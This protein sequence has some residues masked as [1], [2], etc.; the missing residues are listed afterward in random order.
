MWN[1]FME[2]WDIAGYW[3][4]VS[5][6]VEL[7]CKVYAYNVIECN[8]TSNWSEVLWFW[9]VQLMKIRYHD[10]SRSNVTCIIKMGTTSSV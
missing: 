7:V 2:Y 6:S 1:M 3:D 4:I 10:G 9:F 8:S 5:E